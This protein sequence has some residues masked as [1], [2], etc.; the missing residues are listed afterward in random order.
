MEK[1]YEATV[2]I[3]A[4]QMLF[5]ALKIGGAPIDGFRMIETGYGDRL[6]K[7]NLTGGSERTANITAD[8]I[9]TAIWDIMKQI[10]E[11]RE[12]G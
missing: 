11:L 7:V 9:P 12:R 3:T 8:S 5:A 2:R 6:I 1:D 10:P 4:M